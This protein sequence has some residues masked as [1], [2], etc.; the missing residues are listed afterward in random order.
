MH[1]GH[2]NAIRQAK[3]LCDKLIV[4]V[5]RTEAIEARKGTPIMNL[6]ER[7][8]LAKACKWVDEV[9]IADSYDP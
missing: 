6:E 2:F 3:Q 1:S 9:V 5:I 8:S 7:F 4:G